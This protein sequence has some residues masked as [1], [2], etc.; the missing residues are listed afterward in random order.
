MSEI[1]VRV[2]DETY[3]VLILGATKREAMAIR[4][5][6]SAVEANRD[7]AQVNQGSLL[8]AARNNTVLAELHAEY[9]K[10]IRDVQYTAPAEAEEEFV[11]EDEE[12]FPGFYN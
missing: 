2:N 9:K 10:T 11:D 7:F 8:D 4:E 5:A 3:D 6:F 1:K 12:E